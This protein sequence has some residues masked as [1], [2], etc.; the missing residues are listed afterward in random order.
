MRIH[1]FEVVRVASFTLAVVLVLPWTVQAQW[2]TQ[3]TQGI[4]RLPNGSADLSA[5]APRTPDG[6][7]DLSGLW[8]Q[9]LHPGYAANVAADLEPAQV[10]SEAAEVF[11]QRMLEFGKD[12]PST[13][14]C[15]PMGPR[16]ITGSGGVSSTVK[17]IQTPG[18][19][20]LLFEDLAYRQI[21]TYEF[22]MNDQGVVTHLF[23]HSA[24]EV[25]RANRQK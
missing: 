5:P 19:I 2:L 24:E 21:G 15:L 22:V 16:H 1:L 20:I 13:I 4:P 18:V 8:F 10:R 12:D 17:F 9:G 6:K 11:R 23:T 3:P 25:L 7:P 14:G